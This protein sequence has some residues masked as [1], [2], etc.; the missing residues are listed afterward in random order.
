[1]QANRAASRS[2]FAMMPGVARIGLTQT[3]IDGFRT[4]STATLRLVPAATPDEEFLLTMSLA[5][6]TA[7]FDTLAVI[8]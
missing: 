7:G 6:F 1:M 3:D 2:A 5:G 4:G 8:P